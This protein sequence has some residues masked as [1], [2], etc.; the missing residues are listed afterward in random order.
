MVPSG[1]ST[2][3][4]AT[5]NSSCT[6]RHPLD[7]LQEGLVEVFLGLG[8]EAADDLQQHADDVVRDFHRADM[9]KAGH[10]GVPDRGRIST[11]ISPAR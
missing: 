10:E 9:D 2:T 8:L 1:A 3:A 5:R 11:R 4:S 6:F 7:I